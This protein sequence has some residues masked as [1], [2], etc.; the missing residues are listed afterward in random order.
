M[1]FSGMVKEELSKRTGASRH[2]QIAELAAMYLLCGKL[3]M[4]PGS[5]TGFMGADGKSVGC[6]KVLY[7][8]AK[9]I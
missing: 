3:K 8:F 5:G 1:S 6:K 4:Y 2:C 7:N 9:N